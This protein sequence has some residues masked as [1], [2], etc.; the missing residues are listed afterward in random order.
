MRREEEGGLRVCC[1]VLHLLHDLLVPSTS[2]L[3]LLLLPRQRERKTPLILK[4]RILEYYGLYMSRAATFDDDGILTDLSEQLRLDVLVHLNRDLLLQFPLLQR[5]N[6][7][8]ISHVLTVLTPEFALPEDVVLQVWRGAV[9]SVSVDGSCC[10]PSCVYLWAPAPLQRLEV[11]RFLYFLIKGRV[12]EF[13]KARASRLDRIVDAYDAGSFFDLV[14]VMTGEPR[15]FA[16]KSLAYSHML[17]I[18]KE[19][20]EAVLVR[21]FAPAGD[22]GLVCKPFQMP[23][24]R[25]CVCASWPPVRSTIPS[26][27]RL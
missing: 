23:W 22:L 17:L 14:S 16:V 27:Q 6:S 10:F 26:S 20:L 9:V 18:E 4:E 15:V 24:P 19:E 7:G 11:G 1:V 3:L 25:C 5:I 13:D 21:V 12:A 8:F 2:P